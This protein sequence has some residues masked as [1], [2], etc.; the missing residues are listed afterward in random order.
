MTVKNVDVHVLSVFTEYM[1]DWTSDTAF[2]ATRETTIESLDIDDLAAIEIQLAL[3]S[4]FDLEVQ[5]PDGVW[6]EWVTVGDA[7]KYMESIV[8]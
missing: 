6:D 4:E 7:I 3:E 5:I 1:R 2:K 8:P